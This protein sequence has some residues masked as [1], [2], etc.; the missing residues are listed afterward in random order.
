MLNYV[1]ALGM[2]CS[3]ATTPHC[4]PRSLARYDYET[5]Q[6][7]P[8]HWPHDE[9]HATPC[10]PTTTPYCA[11]FPSVPPHIEGMDQCDDS[12]WPHIIATKSIHPPTMGGRKTVGRNGTAPS[13]DR[14]GGTA[15]SDD[16]EGGIAPSD[17]RAGG[18]A[19]SDDR[20]DP[21][22][23]QKG[24]GQIHL[25][26]SASSRKHVCRFSSTGSVP[27]RERVITEKV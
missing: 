13:D 18:T 23:L 9:A 1:Y 17:D 21:P 2:Q 4:P 11:G 25:D 5:T 3:S 20:A 14:A 16:R 6:Q 15:A 22:T 12:E 8:P 7:T 27:W 24:S 19:P 10:S 26:L